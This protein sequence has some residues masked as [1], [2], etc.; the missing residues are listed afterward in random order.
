MPLLNQKSTL[1]KEVTDYQVQ[2]KLVGGESALNVR[3]VIQYA[4]G[5]SEELVAKGTKVNELA[6][7]Q[8][9]REAYF[10]AS[11]YLDINQLEARNKFATP[12]CV[13][14]LVDLDSGRSLILTRFLTNH[15]VAT[16][17]IVLQA[18]ITKTKQI[19]GSDSYEY[20]DF[21][22]KSLSNAAALHQQFWMDKSVL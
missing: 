22:E 13:L 15:I 12:D 11:L 4:D 21:I 18:D 2:G 10:Y 6:S 3:L 19:A 20:K 5:T 7:K 8:K 17:L 1:Q 14:S 16:P 9:Y